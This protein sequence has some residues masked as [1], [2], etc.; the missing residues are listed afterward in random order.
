MIAPPVEPT[1]YLCACGQPVYFRNSSCLNCN[2]PLGYDP[3]RDLV[4]RLQPEKDGRWRTEETLSAS[5]GHLYVRC[6]NLESP[7]ACNWLVPAGPKNSPYCLAC[8]LNRTIP[9]LS[10]PGNAE[11]WRRIETAKRRLIASL[12]RLGLPVHP[13]IEGDPSVGLAFDFLEPDLNSASVITGHSSG[14]I[15]LN[16][17]EAEP[18]LSEQTRTRMRER[19]RTLLGHLRHETGHYYWEVLVREG[20][21]I[22]EFGDESVDYGNALRHYYESGARAGWER[23][24]ISAYATSHPWEDWAECWAHFLHMVD[25]LETA[26]RFGLT[27]IA[28][29]SE[30]LQGSIV[31]PC[32]ATTPEQFHQIASYW[33]RLTIAVNEISAAMG[34]EFFYPFTIS[35][36]V[37]Q[38]LEFVHRMVTSSGSLASLLCP[39]EQTSHQADHKEHEKDKEEHLRDA[40]KGAGDPHEP[41]HAGQ[42]R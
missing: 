15:T 9:N 32:E 26:T 21:R 4:L 25:T 30:V 18:S 3:E 37:L 29:G 35:P 6:A 36:A 39:S 23:N 22:E 11:R 17:E 2:Q 8:R 34:N 19:Y 38:K 1:P 27:V 16:I 42:Q 12:L 31:T 13:K 10:I 41:E 20:G 7:A 28:P 24:F 40:G 33:I 5:H 14:I